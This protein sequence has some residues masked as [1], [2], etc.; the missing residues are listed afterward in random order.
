MMPYAIQDARDEC[1]EL[2]RALGGSWN[3]DNNQITNGHS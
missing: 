2:Y 3:F 1:V